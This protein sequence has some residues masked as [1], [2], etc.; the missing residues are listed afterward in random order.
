MARRTPRKKKNQ[1]KE[2][3]RTLLFYLSS[4]GLIAALIAYLMIYTA[5]DES[6]VALGIQ[7]T[8]LKELE[9]EVST[10]EARVDYLSRPDII[11][12]KARQ[13]L[14]MVTVRPESIIIYIDQTGDE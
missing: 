1:R 12:M 11:A 7:Q 3:F 6:L 4:V 10:L 2:I 13:E 9:T 5:I 8:T 14:G